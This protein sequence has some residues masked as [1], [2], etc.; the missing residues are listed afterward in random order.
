MTSIRDWMASHDT[1]RDGI[2]YDSIDLEDEESYPLEGQADIESIESM[3]DMM[4]EARELAA[5]FVSYLSIDEACGCAMIFSNSFNTSD[6][7]GKMPLL[8]ETQIIK[9]KIRLSKLFKEFIQDYPEL[10]TPSRLKTLFSE[11]VLWRCENIY[12]NAISH[13]NRH[14][15]GRW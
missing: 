3:E 1:H 15:I 9:I 11:S 8:N 5:A 13:R 6:V 4:D 14:N 12:K 10:S 7:I 2:R